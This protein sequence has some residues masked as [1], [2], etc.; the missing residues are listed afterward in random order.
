MSAQRSTRRY[1]AAV[2][3]VV[4]GQ[5][6]P[7]VVG[8]KPNGSDL[9]LSFDD[10]PTPGL[11]EI[12]APALADAG[13]HATFF[14][15][16][17][18]AIRHSEIIRLLVDHGHEVAMHGFEHSRMVGMPHAELTRRLRGARGELEELAGAKVTYFRPPFGAQS[19]MTYIAAR[20][21][22]LTPTGWSLNSVDYSETGA[23]VVMDGIR[24]AIAPGALVLLH[25]GDGD[26]PPGQLADASI[27]ARLEIFEALAALLADLGLRS[28]TLGALVRRNGAVTRR[29]VRGCR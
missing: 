11:T 21:A 2:R 1:A 14:V 10:G 9:T 28:R 16:L 27:S 25:D 3:D 15:L 23:T 8:T 4:E 18:R 7:T 26:R 6:F 20:R 29:W 19:R 5:I 22:A 12:L 13:H 24:S 17:R